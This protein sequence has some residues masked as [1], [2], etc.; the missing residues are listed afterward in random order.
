MS[1]AIGIDFGTSNTAAAT[2]SAGQPR[3]VPL[4][5]GRETLPTAIFLDYAARRTVFGSAAVG[6]MI[7]GQEGR[8]M[9]ALKS[10][11]GTPLARERRQFLNR[12]LSLLDVVAEFLAEIRRRAETEAGTGFR[13]VVSGRPVRFHSVD[14]ERNAQAEIDLR[15]CYHNAGFEEIRFVNEPEAA[16][17]AAGPGAGIGL[18]VDIGGGTSDFTLFESRE[19]AMHALASHGLRLGGTDFDKALSLEKVMPL[20]GLGGELRNEIGPGRHSVPR[21]IF[22]DLASWEKIAF[23]Y[24]PAT[25][26]SVQKMARLA[27]EPQRLGRLARVIENEVGHDV[28]FAVEAAKIGANGAAEAGIDLALVERGL[29]PVLTTGELASTLFPAARAIREAI[30]EVLGQA[31]L[32]P[33]AVGRVIFVGGSSL[34]AV[35]EAEVRAA[36]PHAAAERSDVFTAVV[37]GLA[38]CTADKA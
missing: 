20:L 8:F 19:G 27:V 29:R 26:R 28:A 4:E 17:R 3:I 5:A 38:I 18:I 36:L 21:A 16:A 24:G 34:L 2:F 11:L 13:R 7:D 6:A 12:R 33:K 22:L 1:P 10:V 37:R 35:V 9:R 25:L 15:E 31:G 23:L 32:G 14:P 30:A